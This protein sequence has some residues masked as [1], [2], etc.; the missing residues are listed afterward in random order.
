M[1]RGDGGGGERIWR[2]SQWL[3]IIHVSGDDIVRLLY[4]GRFLCSK[5]C[6]LYGGVFARGV[7][8]CVCVMVCFVCHYCAHLLDPFSVVQVHNTDS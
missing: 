5:L 8:V 3:I 4:T 1:W 2:D 6:A 7:C